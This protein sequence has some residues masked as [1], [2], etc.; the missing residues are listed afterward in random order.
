MEI[1]D[2]NEDAWMY[3]GA[4]ELDAEELAALDAL[5]ASA[6]AEKMGQSNRSVGQFQ[7]WNVQGGGADFASCYWRYYSW[8][9]L[10]P[11]AVK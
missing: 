2:G 3:E 9:S 4:I 5:S 10:Q 1:P 11:T 6:A 8:A 7:A